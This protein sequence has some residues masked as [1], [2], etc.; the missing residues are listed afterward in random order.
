MCPERVQL[1]VG[2]LGLKLG[3]G[4]HRLGRGR[5]GFQ[6]G[7]ELAHEHGVDL[8][9]ALG[10][11]AVEEAAEERAARLDLD[12]ALEAV[13]PDR[14][15]VGHARGRLDVPGEDAA[16]H[17]QHRL[18]VA[19]GA[20]LRPELD[21]DRVAERLREAEVV[22][23]EAGRPVVDPAGAVVEVEADILAAAVGAGTAGIA[24]AEVHADDGGE[25][26]GVGIVADAGQLLVGGVADLLEDRA[27]QVRELGFR[28]VAE[29][30]G[31][32]QE[33]E[34]EITSKLEILLVVCH[35]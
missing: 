15:P 27:G 20:H 32:L 6:R 7:L 18:A 4:R 10:G 29:I 14:R 33:P 21:R 12:G 23:L 13:A 25:D 35:G 34:L 22:D 19:A 3:E 8:L 28:E 24:P 17:R 26:V 9:H 11:E 5:L 2:L 30:V 16:H 31:V 1:V